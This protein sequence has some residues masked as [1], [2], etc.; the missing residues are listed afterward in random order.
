M[1]RKLDPRVFPRFRVDGVVRVGEG[2]AYA[3]LAESLCLAA[4]GAVRDE[5]NPCECPHDHLGRAARLGIACA[6]LDVAITAMGLDHGE[7][8]VAARNDIIRL[9]DRYYLGHE[10]I[11]P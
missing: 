11:R 9:R 8:F 4:E 2:T 7:D 1:I 10:R 6:A 5:D 3:T